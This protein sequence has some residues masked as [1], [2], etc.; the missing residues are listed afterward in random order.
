MHTNQVAEGREGVVVGYVREQLR[1]ARR[2]PAA[3]GTQIRTRIRTLT[4]IPTRT[5]IRI[6]KRTRIKTWKRTQKRTR[7]RA[8]KGGGDD[9][10]C[11]AAAPR[12]RVAG[13]LPKAR[14]QDSDKDADKDSDKDSDKDTDKDSDK[15]A[16]KDSDTRRL[17][18]MSRVSRAMPAGPL[19]VEVA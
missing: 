5:R 17:W 8:R 14:H 11:A 7:I 19:P 6:R 3:P 18:A 10:P 12:S 13:R 1:V 15:D 2:L 9:R 16:D 4:R